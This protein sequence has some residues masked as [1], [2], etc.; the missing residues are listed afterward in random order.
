[1]KIDNQN[2]NNYSGNSSYPEMGPYSNGSINNNGYSNAPYQGQLYQNQSFSGQPYNNTPYMPS[3][4]HKKKKKLPIIFLILFVILILGVI[5]FFVGINKYAGENGEDTPEKAATKYLTAIT[6]GDK[7]AL[8]QVLPPFVTNKDDFMTVV[9]TFSSQKEAYGITVGSIT[10]TGSKKCSKEELK[11]AEKDIKGILK[12]T[13]KEA[14]KVSI[15]VTLSYAGVETPEIQ[16]SVITVIN[17]GGSYY[18]LSSEEAT[19]S[20]GEYTDNGLDIKDTPSTENITEDTNNEMMDEETETGLFSNTE[21]N[22]VPERDTS[23]QKMKF[24][25]AG[26]TYQFPIESDSLL[27][28]NFSQDVLSNS[29][30]ALAFL[31]TTKLTAQTNSYDCV[32]VLF[33][34]HTE[35]TDLLLSDCHVDRVT[36]VSYQDYPSDLDFYLDNGLCFGMTKDEVLSV[37]GNP[38]YQDHLDDDSTK[39]FVYESDGNHS[40][41]TLGFNAT[42][43]LLAYAEYWY[44]CGID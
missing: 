14:Y 17:M 22:I 4:P 28:M 12:L 13:V 41:L 7:K 1:M 37:M 3:S 34:N 16:S 20:E 8:E 10:A 15:S 25:Y 43:G 32:Q 44:D 29:E 42:S 26:K 39:T 31:G 36:M 30:Y 9:D 27:D 23:W 35:H 6:S 19:V 33:K 38:S 24:H 2:Y 18:Y 21:D 5:G 11:E 40:T